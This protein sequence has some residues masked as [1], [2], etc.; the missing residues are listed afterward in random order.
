[1]SWEAKDIHDVVKNSIEAGWYFFDS[2]TM[3]FWNTTIE[4]ELFDNLCFV[5]SEDNFDRS[6]ILYSVRRY[7]P[8]DASV[9]TITFQ[10]HSILEEAIEFAKR[11]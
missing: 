3:E 8:E 5:T 11:Q 7:N 9:D 2:D 10:Q 6:K 1:M 4:T